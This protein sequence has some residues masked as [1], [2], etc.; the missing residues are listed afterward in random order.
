MVFN[1]TENEIIRLN[2]VVR[3]ILIPYKV[4]QSNTAN[5]GKH[6]ILSNFCIEE[7]GKPSDTYKEFPKHNVHFIIMWKMVGKLMKIYEKFEKK[8]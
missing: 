7:K 1:Y 6:E 5:N 8:E 4:R 2:Q 3:W